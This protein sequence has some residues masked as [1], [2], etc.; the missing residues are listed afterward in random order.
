[1]YRLVGRL[2][3]RCFE[4][5]ERVVRLRAVGVRRIGVEIGLQ[6]PRI[7]LAYLPDR[8]MRR[9]MQQ[10]AIGGV[11]ERIEPAEIG[12]RD[13]L[14]AAFSIDHHDAVVAA[15]PRCVGRIAVDFAALPGGIAA[16]P[17]GIAAMPGR[18]AAMPGRVAGMAIAVSVAVSVAV[19]A[20]IAIA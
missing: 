12:G 13:R 16:M 9:G 7:D 11:E 3:Q 17:G 2:R 20:V 18:V 15:V 5:V 8:G 6:P 1:T 4:G 19:S 14:L 10:P